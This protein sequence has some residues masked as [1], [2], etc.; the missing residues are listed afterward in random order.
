MTHEEAADFVMP[1]GKYR[2]QSLTLE[3]IAEDE[4]DRVYLEWLR[5]VRADDPDHEPDDLDEALEVFLDG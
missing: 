5:G 3:Q 2:A 1:I 4:D